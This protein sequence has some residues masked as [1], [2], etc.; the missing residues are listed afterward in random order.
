MTAAECAMFNCGSRT[1][2]N[3]NKGK[4]FLEAIGQNIK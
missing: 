1:R 4:Y 3:S 2:T